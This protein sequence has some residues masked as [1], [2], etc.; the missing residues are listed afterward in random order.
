MF[1]PRTFRTGLL[2]LS[3]LAIAARAQI[4]Q[5]RITDERV[6]PA[7]GSWPHVL[8]C[9]LDGD[10]DA[11]MIS[12]DGSRWFVNDGSAGLDVSQAGSPFVGG[13][14]S[15]VMC[16]GDLDGDGR[17]DALTAAVSTGP[18]CRVSVWLSTGVGFV[19]SSTPGPALQL[20]GFPI[21]FVARHAELADLDLDG[22]RDA[23][24]ETEIWPPPG[25]GA[26]PSPGPL[27]LWLNA[28]GGVFVDA[29]ASFLPL[30]LWPGW[31]GVEIADFDGDGDP[32]LFA[33]A[34][35]NGPL[36]LLNTGGTGFTQTAVPQLAAGSWGGIHAGDLNGDGSADLVR[37]TPSFWPNPPVV[38]VFLST[39]AGSFSTNSTLTFAPGEEI[40]A[41]LLDL[42]GDGSDE[43]VL[44]SDLGVDVHGFGPSGLDPSPRQHL[45]VFG[46]SPIT[47]DLDGDGDGDILLETPQGRRV[48]L[49][50]GQGG[51]VHLA[52]VLSTPAGMAVSALADLDG[53]GDLDLVG[54]ESTNPGRLPWIAWND[55]RGRMA[56]EFPFACG[57][58]CGW[59][60]RQQSLVVPLDADGDGRTDLYFADVGPAPGSNGEDRLGL[61]T[62]GPQWTSLPGASGTWGSKCARAGDL[63]GD[64]DPDLAFGLVAAAGT[65]VYGSTPG[66]V[67]LNL[68]GG[69]F[70]P[71]VGLPAA[72]AAQ[73][74]ELADVDSD[75]DLDI[76]IAAQGDPAFGTSTDRCVW[77]PNAGN[78]SFLPERSVAPGHW[79]VEA[80]D[81]DGD[82]DPDLLLGDEWWLNDGTGGFTFGGRLGTVPAW[83]PNATPHRVNGESA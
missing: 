10:G 35:F 6:A 9:D 1:Q 70:S 31:P 17:D 80:G 27:M 44:A 48:L 60:L 26:P 77:F 58:P 68:G 15:W 14:L 37:V 28:G 12:G 29:T 69:L 72:H 2:F 55:G 81:M 40:E 23:L 62:G 73:D 64:G 65:Y 11:D 42:N 74:L 13:F 22:D 3:A 57:S 34:S 79:Q 75:G 53:D 71:A 66:G 59:I 30:S 21:L 49:N 45:A 83:V 63:D 54:G 52:G 33:G 18:V 47:A 41:V 43:V 32:D 19:R 16:A 51:L 4:P 24:V 46:R 67:S 82:G 38:D 7:M 50:D 8:P 20:A 78:G 36:L 76:V 5:F 25:F 61:N 56:W 39:G